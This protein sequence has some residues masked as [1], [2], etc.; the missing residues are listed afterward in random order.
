MKTCSRCK[1]Y[2]ARAG[3][4]TCS[5]CAH[6]VAASRHQHVK[7][8][9]LGEEWLERDDDDPFDGIPDAELD[10]RA[11]VLSGAPVESVAATYRVPVQWL[12]PLAQR[13]S[14]P[15]GRVFAYHGHSAAPDCRALP[16]SSSAE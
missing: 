9:R 13:A 6:D 8:R 3:L 16:S 12:A 15:I 1:R 4:K 7:I 14:G 10:A 11:L 5:Q 2:P